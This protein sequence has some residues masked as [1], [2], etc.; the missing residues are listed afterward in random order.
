MKKL[1]PILSLLFLLFQASTL[2]PAQVII[3]EFSA[4]NSDQFFDNYG[5]DEDWI[6][7]HNTTN[8]PIDLSGYY[9]S[10]KL[11]NPTKFSI[12]AGVSIPA[13]GYLLVWAS[14]REEYVGGV[15][16][17]NFK[18]TQTKNSESVVLANPSGTIIDFHEI[19][20]PN[21]NRQSWARK[22]DGSLEW[23]IMTNPTPGDPNIGT[24]FEPYL[25]KPQLSPTPGYYPDPVMVSI[26]NPPNASV[27]YYYTTDGSTPNALSTPYSGSFS[28]NNTAIV[29]IIAISNNSNVMESFVDFNTYIISDTHSL[30]VVSISGDDLLDLMN[31]NQIDPIG[32]FELFD[33][34]GQRV[35][36]ASG[37]FNK[38]GNDSWAYDQRGIDYITQDEFGDDHAVKHQIFPEIST[39]DEFQRLILKAAANDN[40]PFEFGGA[41]IR[42]AYVHTLSQKANLHLDERTNESCVMYVNGAYWGVYEIR[43][44]VDDHDYT[45]YY[46]DQGRK[47]IDFIKTWGNTWEEYGSWDDW[48]DLRDYIENNDMADPA[49]YAYV[50]ERLEVM[51]MIDY[52][53]LHS[54]NVSSDWLN[55][56]TAWWRG[57]KTTGGAQKWR[58]ILWDE[59]ATFGHYANYTGVPDQ[60][61]LADP[62]NPEEINPGVDFEGHIS[63]FSNLLENPEFLALYINRY[64]DLNSSYL[65]CDYMIPLLDE[66]IARIQPEMQ[67]QIDRWGGSMNEWEDNV[68][69]L[70]EF[71][72]TRCTVIADGIVDCYE[73]EGITGPYDITIDVEPPGTGKVQANT[74][75][76]LTY[77]WN[78][79]YFGGIEVNFTAIPEMDQIFAY[80]EVN[81]N[82]YTPDQYA[83]AITMSLASGDEITAHFE[84]AVPCAGPF[85]FVF[86]STQTTLIANWQGPINTISYEVRYREAGSS[87]WIVF[88]TLNADVIIDDLLVCTPYEVDIRA[89]CPVGTSNYQ[90]FV[91]QTACATAVEELPQSITALQ[92][93]PNPFQKQ[94]QLELSLAEASALR[95]ELYS[96]TGQL[97]QAKDLGV[98][99]AGSHT[100][101]LTTDQQLPEGMYLL[102]IVSDTGRVVR[103]LVKG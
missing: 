47:W 39:R 77:P 18:I 44:K 2:L 41:H 7:L 12:P 16:H 6:E 98:N 10:D 56:N 84:P 25:D 1:S 71:I 5:E 96:I 67:R 62:C 88:S 27:T 30:P 57:R 55:W 14:N 73:E 89:I 58:Y 26:D 40:Y 99:P 65:S 79:T 21:K 83:E 78:A 52:I 34:A 8:A 43:E 20:T 68:A 95:F 33:E 72:Q 42:D 4:A 81:N 29:K 76:G 3:N 97:I 51:S 9:L 86:D 31:G 101:Q 32:T 17:T 53:I 24:V 70:R 49:N 103:K 45:D 85:G 54:H 23:G 36:D 59:D 11:N 100:F 64:A 35:S 75:V 93:H 50:S 63:L 61:P 87:D 102:A 90:N 38:H 19:D 22:N 46:Y 82:T 37:E 74:V 80:W 69:A 92:V 48:Y 15:L 28:V 13:D 66:M 91:L 94:I 60:S